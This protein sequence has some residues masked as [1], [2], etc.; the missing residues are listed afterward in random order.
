MGIAP[1]KSDE[2]VLGF[3][4]LKNV[5]GNYLVVRLGQTRNGDEAVGTLLQVN[6]DGH[7]VVLD[8]THRSFQF[9]DLLVADNL[10]GHALTF[11]LSS[12]INQQRNVSCGIKRI[13]LYE[14]I[15]VA[16]T[17]PPEAVL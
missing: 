4:I 16:T 11:T 6:V 1:L 5:P 2:Q 3:R 17:D 14:T 9:F 12:A 13:E 7:E 15:R 10:G 8:L